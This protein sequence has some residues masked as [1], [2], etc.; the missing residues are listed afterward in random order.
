MRFMKIY[1]DIIQLH[2]KFK[3]IILSLLHQ[4]AELALFFS[5]LVVDLPLLISIGLR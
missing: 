3:P 5:T 2:Y 4:Y 1:Y